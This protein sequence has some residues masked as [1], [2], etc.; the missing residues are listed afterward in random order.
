[1]ANSTLASPIP[2]PLVVAV[3]VLRP[4]CPRRTRRAV[5]AT[6]PP[7]RRRR[8]S[9]T[10]C[11]RRSPRGPTGRRRAGPGGGPPSA[12]T[13]RPAAGSRSPTRRGRSPSPA[14]R[15]NRGPRRSR[16]AAPGRPC[17]GSGPRRA[18]PTGLGPARWWAVRVRPSST[19]V[20]PRRRRPEPGCSTRVRPCA[21][22]AAP[23][24]PPRH[25]WPAERQRPPRRPAPPGRRRLVGGPQHRGVH[26]RW[27]CGQAICCAVAAGGL[28]AHGLVPWA[29]ARWWA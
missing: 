15:G 13:G 25:R 29:G 9:C 24:T 7:A 28:P 10:S 3:S 14:R 12:P 17:R 8:G 26:D 1:M 6:I 11:P 27:T 21:G 20:R 5:P 16:P 23:R 18:D 19:R 22:W 2:G 4:R